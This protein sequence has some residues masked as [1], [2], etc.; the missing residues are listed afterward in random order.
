M[1]LASQLEQQKM[2]MQFDFDRQ[3]KEM[4]MQAIAQ[5]EKEIENRKDKR[6]KMD[7]TQQSKM[8]AQ[9]KNDLPL[10]NERQSIIL[11]EFLKDIPLN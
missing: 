8:I 2:Q 5:K 11:D 4:D 7:G 6:I 9:R 10:Q 3:L 1:E